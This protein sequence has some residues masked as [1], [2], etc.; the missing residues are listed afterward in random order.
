M[1]DTIQ[2]QSDQGFKEVLAN[3]DRSL[4]VSTYQAA[5]AGEQARPM[6]GSEKG[7]AKNN[8]RRAKQRQSAAT[9]PC[10]LKL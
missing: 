8:N 4:A 5:K 3:L 9:V 10:F 7:M 2:C 6:A 1:L